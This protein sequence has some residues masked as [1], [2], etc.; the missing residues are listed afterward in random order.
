MKK[1]CLVEE[2]KKGSLLISVGV[3]TADMMNLGWEI[4]LLEKTGVKLLHIDVMDGCIWPKITVGAPFLGGLKTTMLKDVHLLIDKPENHI[5]DFVKAGADIIIFS[6]EYCDDVSQTL[7]MISQMENANDPEREILKGISLNPDTPIDSV[8]GVI[9]DVDIVLLLAVGPKTG[10]QAFIS[11][12]PGKIAE[13]KKIKDDILIFVDGAIKKDNIAEVAA[14]GPNVIIT[15]SAVFDGKD[16][17]GNAK[18][19]METI[20]V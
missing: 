6:V 18:F 19:M 7:G 1:K 11:E 16:P 13:L 14:M 2:L 10:K 5:E 8:T 20:N 12:L 17:A 15:G 9:D 3:L 4:Q